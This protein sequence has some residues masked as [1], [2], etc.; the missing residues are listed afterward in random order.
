MITLVFVDRT[1]QEVTTEEAYRMC[2][3]PRIAGRI[4]D[5]LTD[6]EKLQSKLRSIMDK[7]GE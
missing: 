6:D 2:Q 3:N 4:I 1:R 7:V 5:A